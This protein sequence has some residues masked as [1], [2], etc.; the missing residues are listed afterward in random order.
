MVEIDLQKENLVKECEDTSISSLR[1]RRQPKEQFVSLIFLFFAVLGRKPKNWKIYCGRNRHFLVIIGIVS[2]SGAR[3]PTVCCFIRPRTNYVR[4]H[5][6]DIECVRQSAKS[7]TCCGGC[8]IQ[9][10]YNLI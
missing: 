8:V 6:V 10:K 1:V 2:G 9:G 4:I 5:P 3:H 7:F